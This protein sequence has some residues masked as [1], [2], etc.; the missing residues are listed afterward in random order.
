MAKCSPE[1]SPTRYILPE[2]V[3][4]ES[5]QMVDYSLNPHSPAKYPVATKKRKKNK[6]KKTK[7]GKSI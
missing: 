2:Q 3:E 4:G 6:D 5:S 7:P 1:E